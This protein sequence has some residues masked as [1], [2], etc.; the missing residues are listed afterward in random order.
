M[1]TL[2]RVF[3]LPEFKTI[4]LV[5]GKEGIDRTITGVNVTESDDLAEFFRQNE[6]IVT[7]GINMANDLTKLMNMVE[8]AYQRNACGMVINTGPYI[9]YIP[10]SIVSFADQMAF[11]LFRMPWEYRVAD[12]LKLSVQFLMTVQN[13]PM[14]RDF[15]LS[16]ILFNPD[17]ND[18]DMKTELAKRGFEN[19]TT[20]AIV[21]CELP[22]HVKHQESIMKILDKS[23]NDHYERTLSTV[24]KNQYIVL[25][26]TFNQGV[27]HPSFSKIVQDVYQRLEQLDFTTLPLIA[28]GENYTYISD[29][30]KSY[31]EALKVI[32]LNRK[33]ARYQIYS[34][35]DL[36]AYKLI[37]GARDHRTIDK[38]HHDVL[39]KLYQYDKSNETDYV[40]FLRIYLEEDG[41]T[42]NI[43]RKKFIHRN[44]VLYKIK[45]IESILNMKL[46]HNFTKTTLTLAFMIEDLRM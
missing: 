20:Y 23:L 43:S 39:G 16:E 13:K 1:T 17:F 27:P 15:V 31:D 37:L 44:T 38:Y 6:L 35:Q 28:K 32:Q 8:T 40:S 46:D 25:V 41:R 3:S 7:T 14:N 34:Y 5:A 24:F 36:G 19:E 26:D 33:H 11:P 22:N 2:R 4:S 42:T 21:V 18:E 30:K 45:K 12:F 9:P 10:E 29:V